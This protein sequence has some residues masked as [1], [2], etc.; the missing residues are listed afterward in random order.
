MC[1]NLTNTVLHFQMA[2]LMFFK[3]HKSLQQKRC[4][5]IP[6][7]VNNSSNSG[8]CVENGVATVTETETYQDQ[9]YFGVSDD[10]I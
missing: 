7:R 8:R 2:L 1:S 10:E 6:R 9:V 5:A 3:L 4:V